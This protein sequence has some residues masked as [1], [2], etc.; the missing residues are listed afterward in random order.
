LSPK[1]EVKPAAKPGAKPGPKPAAKKTNAP[2]SSQGKKGKYLPLIM[3]AGFS[4]SGMVT[5]LVGVAVLVIS[6]VSG[7]TLINILIRTG[8]AVLVMGLLAWFVTYRLVNNWVEV[9]AAEQAAQ[10]EELNSTGSTV[11]LKA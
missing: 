6:Y 8:V 5:L 2:A 1:A 7:A 10:A 3:E 9:L 4:V 11:E